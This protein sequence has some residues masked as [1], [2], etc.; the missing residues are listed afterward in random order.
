MMTTNT[1]S[2]GRGCMM[3]VVNV[4]G[5]VDGIRLNGGA[6]LI[7]QRNVK[8]IVDKFVGIE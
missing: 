7:V 8:K 3:F 1:R 6:H 2:S 4:I 5:V